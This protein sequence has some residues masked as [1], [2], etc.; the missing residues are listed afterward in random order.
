MANSQGRPQLKMRRSL[1]GLPPLRLPAGITCRAMRPE[2]AG[3]WIDILNGCGELGD[4][5]LARAEQALAGSI[6]PDRV[7]FLCAGEEPVATACVCLHERPEGL[8]E[9]EIGWVAVLP[10]HQGR[11]LGA[12]V[13][14]AACHAA[15]ALGFEDAFLLTDD[16][17]L[18]ALKTYLNLGFEPDCWHESH[19]ERWAA[20]RQALAAR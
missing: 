6:A 18:P 11:R 15:R 12:C 20:A 14:L 1:A 2:E 17:R 19:A 3:A 5:D 9:A 10:A 13:T 16:R 7:L 4:W 8:R